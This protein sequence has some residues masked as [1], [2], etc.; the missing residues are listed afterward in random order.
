MIF[1]I[2]KTITIFRLKINN[3]K[4]IYIIYFFFNFKQIKRQKKEINIFN[5]YYLKRNNIVIYYII[6]FKK[7]FNLIEL[8]NNYV[9]K[10]YIKFNFN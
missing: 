1:L 7:L 2:K 5:C 4:N 3:K 6:W 10:N 8:E 9:Y